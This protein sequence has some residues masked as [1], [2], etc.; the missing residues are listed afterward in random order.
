MALE[1]VTC[2]NYCH[3]TSLFYYSLSLGDGW[4]L[5]ALISLLSLFWNALPKMNSTLIGQRKKSR[6]TTPT[7]VTSYENSFTQIPIRLLNTKRQML[8]IILAPPYCTEET[9]HLTFE[10]I[11]N[12]SSKTLPYHIPNSPK[13]NLIEHTNNQGPHATITICK[14]KWFLGQRNICACRNSTRTFRKFP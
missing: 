1:I 3:Y 9:N 7:Y 5:A 10:P 2:L 13:I 8:C 4:L 12:Q 11:K 6:Y 14:I